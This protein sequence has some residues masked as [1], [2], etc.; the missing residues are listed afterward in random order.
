MAQQKSNL[1]PRFGR[2]GRPG[3]LDHLHDRRSCGC[4]PVKTPLGEFQ[5]LDFSEVR[6]DGSYILEAGK[7][8]TN[9]FRIDANV[10]RQTILKAL[11]FLYAER[12]GMA[13]PGVHGICHRDWTVV[14]GDMRI[15]INGGWHDAGDLT[16]GL[17]NTGEIVYSLFSLAERLRASEQARSSISGLCKRRV[18][19]WTG[20]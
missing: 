12:C 13:I 11:N 3:S 16:Q 10:W 7:A 8:R 6:Q 18:G 19:A 14:H 17:G 15:A 1:E 9:P 20:F 2:H 5:V 4:R